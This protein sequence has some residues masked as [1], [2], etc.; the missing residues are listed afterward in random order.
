MTIQ[1]FTLER[2]LEA[3]E[4]GYPVWVLDT[5]GNES[6]DV[7]IGAKAIVRREVLQQHNI[8]AIPDD[9]TLRTVTRD[10]F[11]DRWDL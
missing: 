8:D 4:I 11:E 1:T 5:G 6:D 9:W 7:L 2:I 3:F 10:E